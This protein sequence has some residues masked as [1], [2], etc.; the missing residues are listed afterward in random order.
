M[1]FE[2]LLLPNCV[3][4]V[5]YYTRLVIFFKKNEF[6]HIDGKILYDNY[7]SVYWVAKN[8]F[9]ENCILLA[10]WKGNLENETRIGTVFSYRFSYRL[11]NYINRNTD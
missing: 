3:L 8:H 11:R 6:D 4:P 9:A 7:I 2:K 10:P 5:P 1:K